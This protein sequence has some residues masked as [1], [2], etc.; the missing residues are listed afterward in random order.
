MKRLNECVIV[1]SVM[2]R[3]ILNIIVLL[4]QKIDIFIKDLTVLPSLAL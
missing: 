3:I 4:F 2:Y 1:Q